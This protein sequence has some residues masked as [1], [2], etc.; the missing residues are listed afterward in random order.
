MA[1]RRRQFF[2]PIIFLSDLK[3]VSGPCNMFVPFDVATR[4]ADAENH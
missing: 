3:G 2:C 1:L 4:L